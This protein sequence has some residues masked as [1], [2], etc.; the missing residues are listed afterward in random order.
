MDNSKQ[1]NLSKNIAGEI[2]L[3]GSKSYTNRGLILAA[4]AQG[5][6][7]LHN[8]SQS[9]DSYLLIAALRNL[10]VGITSDN[11][12]LR[13]FG[14]NGDIA[15]YF[16]KINV[17]MAGTTLRFLIPL[18]C[19]AGGEIFISGTPRLHERPIGDLVNAMRSL[20]AVIEYGDKDGCAPI[21][22]RGFS[23]DK[24]NTQVSVDNTMSSQ[25]VSALLLCGAAFPHGLH[26]T[27]CGK[28]I[29]QS[30]IDM[31]LSYLKMFCVNVDKPN[32]SIYKIS[33]QQ[34]LA[35]QINIEGDATGA[36]YFWGLA[37]LSRGRIRVFNVSKNSAQGD[38]GFV[39]L[40]EEMGCDI[41]YGENWIEVANNNDLQ[42]ICCD[43]TLMPDSA[44]TLAVLASVAHGT[45]K[46][47]GLSTLKHKETD[48]CKAVCHE[49]QKLGIECSYDDDSMSITGGSHL[50]E[51]KIST[52][53]D[54]RMAMSFSL[55]G[56]VASIYIEN[57]SVVAKSFPDF[58]EKLSSLQQN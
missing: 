9:N 52:Y 53:D 8:Y 57:P 7:I 51:V 6:T 41:C 34:V 32:K 49:L 36:T 10:G 13:I 25:F 11:E 58:W 37:A 33:R 24:V 48:R 3:S 30:Y 28:E 12:K 22:V 5:E 47:S 17:G 20:G 23:S 1:V 16:G 46:I 2:Y 27:I 18:C 40:L 4:L 21:I 14:T 45:T 38:I 44:Q 15:P 55:L 50:N 54:H 26:L 42:S 31:T 29:S 43:M 19:I 35:Q 39:S 56:C